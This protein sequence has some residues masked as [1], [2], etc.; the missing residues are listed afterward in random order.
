MTSGRYS[1]H[2]GDN[3]RTNQL[4][5]SKKKWLDAIMRWQAEWK[6]LVDETGI[7]PM[8]GGIHGLMLLSHEGISLPADLSFRSRPKKA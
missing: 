5:L 2:F 8:I 4:E 1:C 6:Q 3:M 7:I